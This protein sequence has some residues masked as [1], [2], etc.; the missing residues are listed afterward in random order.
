M[1]FTYVLCNNVLKLYHIHTYL[2]IS[3][4]NS[5]VTICSFIHRKY[6]KDNYALCT[7]PESGKLRSIE[8]SPCFQEASS[9]GKYTDIQISKW[10]EVSQN[11]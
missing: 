8:N 6:L 1:Y 11:Q 7:V 10:F 5:W 4:F 3:E 2:Q 9:L